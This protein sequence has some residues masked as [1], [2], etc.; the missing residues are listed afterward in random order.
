MFKTKGHK[1]LI[2]GIS[3][4]GTCSLGQAIS[5]QNYFPIKEPFNQGLKGGRTHVYP[6]KDFDRYDNVV[7]KSLAL[8]KPKNIDYGLTEFQLKFINDFDKTILLDRRDRKE[9]NESF[10][11]LYWRIETN[12]RSLQKWHSDII[13]KKFR[14]QFERDNRYF[15]LDLQKS[16]INEISRITNI[17]IT[18]YEDLYGKDR[19]K[20][21]EIIKSWQ[22]IINEQKLNDDL[23]PKFKLRQFKRSII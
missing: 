17:P 4:S 20:S 23:N 19:N 11:H 12:Q 6:I 8:Q 14:K 2:L 7:V 15:D 9:H 3:R 18:Y 1:I 22:I 5:N 16:Q 13:S 21:L 10:L